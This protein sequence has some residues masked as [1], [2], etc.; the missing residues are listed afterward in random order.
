MDI[1]SRFYLKTPLE[2][3]LDEKSNPINVFMKM[4]QADLGGM[5]VKAATRIGQRVYVAMYSPSVDFPAWN[6]G[7]FQVC[8]GIGNRS[9]LDFSE[10]D[11]IQGGMSAKIG[12]DLTRFRH[13]CRGFRRSTTDRYTVYHPSA[14][15][16]VPEFGER[17]GT[18]VI[19][20]P[21]ERNT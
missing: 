2:V 6:C 14:L 3:G 10:I 1:P 12:G 20:K 21:G 16:R 18:L 9:M 7:F 11:L 13:L 5:R 15:K 19:F 17:V 8:E 4:V